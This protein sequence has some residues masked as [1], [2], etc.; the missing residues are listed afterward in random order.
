MADPER[1]NNHPLYLYQQIYGNFPETMDPREFV[2]IRDVEFGPLY[3]EDGII[4][5]DDLKDSLFF[6]DYNIDG[7]PNRT[8]RIA[9][10]NIIQTL[11][12]IYITYNDLYK[13]AQSN[14][15]LPP[16]QYNKQYFG[17]DGI[18][19]KYF[20]RLAPRVDIKY[21][22]EHPRDIRIDII[23]RI[24]QD[25]GGIIDEKTPYASVFDSR[26]ATPDQL[27][28]IKKYNT[29]IDFYKEQNNNN[30]IP[31]IDIA[32]K[33]VGGKNEVQLSGEN[34][35]MPV[36]DANPPLYMQVLVHELEQD[37]KNSLEGLEKLS[38][39]RI[40]KSAMKR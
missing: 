12:K 2:F 33:I 8:Y 26:L 10:K 32:S 15:N 14:Q 21:R 4:I 18:I 28:Q 16:S 25:R 35:L 40:V 5:L 29:N 20:P 22:D 3:D 31:F 34:D 19:S 38:E 37:L 36:Y 39:S 7:D 13:L 27:Y 1:R 30:H 6:L 11:F 9:S 23:S 24:F 17:D